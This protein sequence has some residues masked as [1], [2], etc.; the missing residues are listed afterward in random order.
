MGSFLAKPTLAKVASRN[1]VL[2]YVLTCPRATASTYGD[3]RHAQP[4]PPGSIV[5][6]DSASP[7]GLQGH[8][9]RAL[10]DLPA[11]IGTPVSLQGSHRGA[12][13]GVG[14]GGG[15]V[16]A[17]RTSRALP[18]GRTVQQARTGSTSGAAPWTARPKARA[19]GI[20]TAVPWPSSVHPQYGSHAPISQP[21]CR[22]GADL[23][24]C[25]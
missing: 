20:L 21:Q 2:I 11:R 23:A 15:A 5:C 12:G 17:C 9:S 16:M 13:R 6:A 14:R 24:H 10:D 18:G 25:P 3:R 4:P 8:G 1:V 7:A 22:E 19:T